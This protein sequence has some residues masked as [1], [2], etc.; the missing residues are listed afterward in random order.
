MPSRSHPTQRQRRL[1]TE[2]RRLR[3]RAGM[4]AQEAGTAVKMK[5]YQVSHL[6]AGRVGITPGRLRTL[7]HTYGCTDDAY[8]NALLAM[9]DERE[10]HWWEEYRDLLPPGYL[11]IT[12]LEHST[13]RMRISSS[14]HIPG[15]LQAEAHARAIFDE[16]VTP[17]PEREKEV[18]ITHRMQRQAILYG[19]HPPKLEAVLHEAALRMQFGGR[20][21]AAAQLDHLLSATEHT[22]ITVRV[23]PFTAGG[24]PGSGQLV[25]YAHGPVP[26]LDTVQLDSAHATVFLTSE[27]ELDDY[28]G[29]FDRTERKSLSPSESRDL[30]HKI[31]KEL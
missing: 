31:A 15:L 27:P 29:L 24:I 28:R 8:V 9:A 12:E 2:L 10:K 25:F 18:R 20:K 26:R 30:I 22:H 4:S 17:L 3:E 14:I 1:G 16:A 23:V 7:T 13:Q 6:E 21:V 5:S 19:D 11:D